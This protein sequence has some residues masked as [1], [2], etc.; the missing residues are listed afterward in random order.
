MKVK[1]KMK[2]FLSFL[3]SGVTAISMLSATSFA[4]GEKIYTNSPED[5]SEHVSYSVQ[6][7]ALDNYAYMTEYAM[8]NA[9]EDNINVRQLRLGEPFYIFSEES[10]KQEQIYYF[11]VLNDEDKFIYTLTAIC[12]DKGCQLSLDDQM[13]ERLNEI[14]YFNVDYIFYRLGENITAEN[15]NSKQCISGYEYESSL[16]S[17]TF[18]EK[19]EIYMDTADLLCV[20]DTDISRV[21]EPSLAVSGYAPEFDIEEYGVQNTEVRCK[22]CNAQGQGNYKLCWAACAA[23]VINYI[24]GSNLSAKKIS[25][26]VGV[27]FDSGGTISDVEAALHHYKIYYSA[28]GERL[29]FDIIRKNISAK[30][31]TVMFCFAPD[32]ALGHAVT[33]MGFR[34]RLTTNKYITVWNSALNSGQGGFT[35]VKYSDDGVTIPSGG[36]AYIWEYSVSYYQK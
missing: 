33:I 14:N 21:D 5:F 2:K 30:K 25:N 12:T 4:E 23:T 24:Q 15:R 16:D 26:I 36:V 35:V 28:I 6:K 20:V 10:E 32:K 9:G 13:A 3:L 1:M 29:S 34:M 17:L 27:G 22:L 11:P 31:P 8:E 18:E 19:Y 7:E